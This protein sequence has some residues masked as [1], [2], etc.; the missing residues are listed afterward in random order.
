MTLNTNDCKSIIISCLRLLF[1][2]SFIIIIKNQPVSY[3]WFTIE[4]LKYNWKVNPLNW[5]IKKEN[6]NSFQIVKDTRI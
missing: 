3:A 2:Y 4:T 1:N 5:I 6:E